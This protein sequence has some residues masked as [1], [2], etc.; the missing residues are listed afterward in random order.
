ML[1]LQEHVCYI[2]YSSHQIC[3]HWDHRQHMECTIFLSV[4]TVDTLHAPCSCPSFTVHTH[5]WYLG[6]N[7]ND[8]MLMLTT[9]TTIKSPSSGIQYMTGDM[10]GYVL[11]WR[12]K[13]N[14][15]CIVSSVHRLA[16]A[17][18]NTRSSTLRLLVVDERRHRLDGKCSSPDEVSGKV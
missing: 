18:G 17:N 4:Y 1:H 10:S 15:D 13:K 11:S 16:P 6:H 3:W 7:I 9:A 12:R 14:W 8:K 2:Q 5:S